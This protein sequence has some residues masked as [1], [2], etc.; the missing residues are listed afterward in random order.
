MSAAFDSERF[1]K[2]VEDARDCGFDVVCSE[3]GVGIADET[4]THDTGCPLH[5][6]RA[7]AE[8]TFLERLGRIF[9]DAD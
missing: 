1:M 3:C 5:E 4:D 2:N 9:G 7:V 6:K 8:T